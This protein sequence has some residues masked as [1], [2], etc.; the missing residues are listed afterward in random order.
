MK[1]KPSVKEIRKQSPLITK[2]DPFAYIPD[3]IAPYFVKL[4]LYTPITANHVSLVSYLLYILCAF[5]IAINRCFILALVLLQVVILL[6]CIDGALA[7]AKKQTSFLGKFFEY[8]SHETGPSFIFFAVGSYL[9]QTLYDPLYLYLGGL[10]VLFSLIINSF[11]TAKQRIIYQHIRKSDRI[12]DNLVSGERIAENTKNPFLI[13][14]FNAID[15]LSNLCFSIYAITIAYIFGFLH[16]L[17]SFY[18]LYFSFIAIFKL[19]TELISG[20]K[21]YGLR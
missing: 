9:Y 20:F 21:P 11:G 19:V 3:Y 8:T 16:Y 5:L 1:S 14:L 18:F 2:Y 7:R 15:V 17:F 10:I 6:D 13:V 4:L 12:P